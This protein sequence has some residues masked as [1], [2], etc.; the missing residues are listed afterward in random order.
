MTTFNTKFRLKK[1]DPFDKHLN[2]SNIHD[3]LK[4]IDLDEGLSNYEK[5]E[6]YL[7]LKGVLI[8]SYQHLPYFTE[9]I[10]RL[11]GNIQSTNIEVE[12]DVLTSRG[13]K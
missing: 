13:K 8:H 10:N 12:L 5:L 7:E 6:Y 3:V 2:R 9:E 11:I 1:T 4:N